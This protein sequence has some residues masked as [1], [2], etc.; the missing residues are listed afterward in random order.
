MV[1]NGIEYGLMQAYAEGFEIMHASEYPLDLEAVAKAWMHGTVIRSWLLELAGRAFEQHGEDLGDI[2]GW[3]ADSGE[4]RWTVQEAIDLDVPGA[5]HHAVAAD[6]LPQPP[7]GELR[8]AGARRAAPAV[9]RPRGQDRELRR[10]GD[11]TTPTQDGRAA[12]APGTTQRA[13]RPPRRP[14]TS[15][16]PTTSRDARQPAARGHCASSACPSRASSSSSARPAT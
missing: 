2:Q 5:G 8:G 3:V 9:R 10:R 15:T 4:G 16:R 7:G 14:S 1:H 11:A 12:T 6:P 13:R